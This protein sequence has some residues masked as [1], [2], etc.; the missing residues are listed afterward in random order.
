MELASRLTPGPC[1][2]YRRLQIGAESSSF[3]QRKGAFSTLQALRDALYKSTAAAAAAA[4]ATTTTKRLYFSD[5]DTK[6][7]A[8][9]ACLTL[10]LVSGSRWIRQVASRLPR[11]RLVQRQTF[12]ARVTLCVVLANAHHA[13]VVR[14]A[15]LAVQ[16]T[17][18]SAP[19][20]SSPSVNSKPL[21]VFIRWSKK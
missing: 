7:R 2:E 10:T 20:S 9:E 15:L 21:S 6:Q 8:T 12:F 3:L 11:S 14:H 17:P 13:S 16:V 18:T 1:S 4:A 19:S 5:H